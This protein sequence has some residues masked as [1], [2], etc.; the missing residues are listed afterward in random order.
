MAGLDYIDR[1]V[2]NFVH[3]RQSFIDVEKWMEAKLKRHLA[4]KNVEFLWQSRVKMPAS[5]LEK[6]RKREKEGAYEDQ[7][8]NCA[9]LKDLVVSGLPKLKYYENFC[10]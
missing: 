3:N 1:F 9:A 10:V 7:E 4:E 5:L 8:S 6:L 2:A